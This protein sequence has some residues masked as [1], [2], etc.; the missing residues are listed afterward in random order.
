VSQPLYFLPHVQWV[1][2]QNI[3]ITRSII[4]EA[5]LTDIFSDVSEDHV[6]FNCLPGRGPGELS[7]T[8]IFYTD[9]R[10]PPRRMGYYENEQTW[11]P[12]G[13]GSKC[14][15]G[16]DNDSPPKPDEMRRKRVHDGYT[17]EL[18]DGA[19]WTIPVIRRPDGSTGLPT[20]MVF[21][22]AGKY[23]EPIKPAYLSY[24]EAS[25]K[26]CDWVFAESSNDSIDN[27][28]ALKLAIEAL[29]LN[30]RYGMQEH[31]VL[32]FIDKTNCQVLLMLSV[33]LPRVRAE[34]EALQKKT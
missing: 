29:N 10:E 4:R 28:E 9:N 26:V 6:G 16:I 27:P 23:S 19:R 11:H 7:G 22:A 1:R 12:V 24:W 25:A 15:I 34:M 31:N 2:G 33:D 14:W 18:A 5:G 30:Y 17:L 8:I 21:D 20:D 13:D 3:A 32:R